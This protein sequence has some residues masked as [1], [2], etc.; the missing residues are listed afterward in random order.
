[1]SEGTGGEERREGQQERLI[2][3][4]LPG[5][6]DEAELESLRNTPEL[7]AAARKTE[8]LMRATRRLAEQEG[9]ELTALRESRLVQRILSRTTREDLSWRGDWE[10]WRRFIVERFTSSSALRWVAASLLV[11]LLALPFFGTEV[12]RSR[13]KPVAIK[14]ELPAVPENEPAEVLPPRSRWNPAD[15]PT[16][17]QIENALRRGRYRLSRLPAVSPPEGATLEHGPLELRLLAERARGLGRNGAGGELAPWVRETERLDST[18]PFQAGLW[19][20]VLLDRHCL[21]G[22]QPPALAFVL[23]RLAQFEADG[24]AT[25]GSRAALA[26]A[27]S[28]GLWEAPTGF[29]PSGAPEPFSAEELAA[30]RRE[31]VQRTGDRPD[32]LSPWM[33]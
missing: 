3:L 28:Y 23:S 19:A 17:S 20:Q 27:R 29:D 33:P 12:F 2:E 21:S 25:E 22:D 24:Q 16:P 30:L 31:L 15:G 14:I 8:S 10:L 1:V 11:H 5:S 7:A 18:S 9:G 6:T 13:E 32:W 4:L 26:R